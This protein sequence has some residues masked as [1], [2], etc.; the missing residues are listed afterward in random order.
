MLPVKSRDERPGGAIRGRARRKTIAMHP[1]DIPEVTDPAAFEERLHRVRE[2]LR[3]K[4]AADLEHE[5]PGLVEAVREHSQ[6]SSLT[7]QF[8]IGVSFTRDGV[9]LDYHLRYLPGSERQEAA[10]E[11][12]KQPV[13]ATHAYLTF[14]HPADPN[15]TP[16]TLRGALLVTVQEAIER[17]GEPD[18][19]ARLLSDLSR[20]WPESP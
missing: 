9:C 18:E 3:A 6:A 2:G 12:I 5:L 11:T 8:V 20:G 14:R 16:G 1:T 17:L 13:D 15:F 4:Q 7:A 10:P 19:L